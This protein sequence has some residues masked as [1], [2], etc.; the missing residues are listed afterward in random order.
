[1]MTVWDNVEPDDMGELDPN[2]E[3]VDASR[4]DSDFEEAS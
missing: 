2:P 4:D 1:M 3:D